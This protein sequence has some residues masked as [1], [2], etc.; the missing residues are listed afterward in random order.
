MS[1]RLSVKQLQR[2]INAATDRGAGSGGCGPRDDRADAFVALPGGIGTL[3]ELA[4]QLTWAQLGQHRHPVGLL[5]VNGY[6]DELVA[7]LDKMT[8]Q[9]FLAPQH[10]AALIVSDRVTTLLDA[11]E[12]YEAP[13][14]DVRIKMGQT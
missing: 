2:R 14:A 5:N 10:R 9:G 1:A 3:E 13:P 6:F 4:G 7:F 11:F 12:Q 8:E